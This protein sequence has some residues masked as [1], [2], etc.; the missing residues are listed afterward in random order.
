MN[1]RIAFSVSAGAAAAA[2]L[3][4]VVG[5]SGADPSGP[6]LPPAKQA[7]EQAVAKLQAQGRVNPMPKGLPNP[8][9]DAGAAIV[10][11]MGGRAAGD[12]VLFDSAQMSR[13]PTDRDDQFT[14]SWSLTSPGLNIDV[15]AGSLAVDP[16]QGLMMVVGW[17]TDRT[18]IVGG[19]TFTTPA[20][21]GAETIIGA[22]GHVLS[23]RSANGTTI[24]FDP[25]A[26]VFL[27]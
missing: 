23:L 13:P 27:P 26:G 12:G 5:V 24:S 21:A 7:I 3:I 22:S 16:A 17:N 8:N 20:K 9:T 11:P 10:P 15:W 18:S 1:R 6:Q 25:V 19:A 2:V 14:S 4:V